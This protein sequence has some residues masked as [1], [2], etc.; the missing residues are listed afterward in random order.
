MVTAAN[1]HEYQWIHDGACVGADPTLFH[2]D[3]MATEQAEEAKA[4]CATCRV[5][6]ECLEYAVA[7]DTRGVWG[8]TVRRERLVIRRVRAAEARR[9]ARST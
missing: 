8:G 7:R 1:G 9:A 5:K 2:P 3:G 6:T 4:I